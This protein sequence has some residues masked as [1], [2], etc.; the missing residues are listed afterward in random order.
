VIF[1]EFVKSLKTPFMSGLTVTKID[2]VKS[3]YFE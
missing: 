2:D 1:D 3:D